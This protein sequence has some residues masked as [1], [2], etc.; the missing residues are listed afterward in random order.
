MMVA[1]TEA[2]KNYMVSM[3]NITFQEMSSKDQKLS[4]ILRI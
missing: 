1:S 3:R 4:N 2:G